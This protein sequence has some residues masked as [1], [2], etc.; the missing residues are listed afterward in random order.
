MSSRMPSGAVRDS[1]GNSMSSIISF[2]RDG[3]MF[4]FLVE[5]ARLISSASPTIGVNCREKS[6]VYSNGSSAGSWCVQQDR[7]YEPNVDEAIAV[8]NT[9]NAVTP[10]TTA[11]GTIDSAFITEAMQGDN[12]EVAIGQLAQAEERA[13]R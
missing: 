4:H 11:A 7:H 5:R 9:T 8:E 6:C 10:G 12:A 1:A 2:A 13:K 3:S